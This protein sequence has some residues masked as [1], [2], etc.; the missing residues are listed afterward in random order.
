M[1][2]MT[3]RRHAPSV[4]VDLLALME[5]DPARYPVLLESAA[6]GAPTGRYDLL[7]A[8]PGAALTLT[9]DGAL[10]GETSGKSRFL[11]AL[12]AWWERERRPAEHPALPFT[13]GW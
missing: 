1:L 12:S 9:A 5:R 10:H 6:V 11:E 3:L 13:G 2:T 7:L 8:A 4:P